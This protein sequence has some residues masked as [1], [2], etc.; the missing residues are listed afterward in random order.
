LVPELVR[1]GIE[2]KVVDDL[3]RFAAQN[4]SQTGKFITIYPRNDAQ[5]RAIADLVSEILRRRG[6]RTS[7]FVQPPGEAVLGHGVF[8]R[9]GRFTDGNLIDP[10]TG[11]EI[12]N[13]S[14][15]ILLP[16]GR[17]VPDVRGVTR[18]DGISPL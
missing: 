12:P 4:G 6:L 17:L 14:D 2:H 9:Y 16:D 10:R 1:R 5:A 18:P 8:G 13:S 3:A 11:R 7:D 15:K